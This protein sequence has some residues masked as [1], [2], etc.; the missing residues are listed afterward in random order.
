M[1][2]KVRWRSIV[3]KNIDMLVE[4]GMMSPTG[5]HF[6]IVHKPYFVLVCP[7]LR[8]NFWGT[9]VRESGWERNSKGVGR[10]W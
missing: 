5:R 3:V 7:R 9:P 8:Y 6:P 10:V 1:P 4:Y 2:Y